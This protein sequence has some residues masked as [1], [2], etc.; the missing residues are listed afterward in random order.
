MKKTISIIGGGA[1]AIMCACELDTEKYE[2]TIYEK[3]KALGRKFLVAGKGGFN[4]THSEDIELFVDRY[5]PKYFLSDAIQNF[6]NQHLRNWL[7][8]NGILTFIGSSKRVYPEKGIKPIEVLKAF[9]SKMQTNKVHI[10]YSHNWLGWNESGSLNFDGENEVKSDIV[11]FALGG[12]SW[13]V[14]GSNGDWLGLF[15]DKGVAVAPFRASNCN[16]KVDWDREL[17]PKIEGLPLKNIAVSIDGVIQKGEAIITKQGIEGNAIYALSPMIRQSLDS[18]GEAVVGIDLKPI[19]DISKIKEKLNNSNYSKITEKL[20]NELKISKVQIELIK[21]IT[22][23]EEFNNIDFLAQIIKNLP[24]KITGLSPIDEAISTVGG[25]ALTEVNE[26][27]E[28]NKRL[29][30]FCIGEMLSWDA[31]T[32]GYLLQGCFSMGV[33]VAKALNAKN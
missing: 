14:T 33:A 21:S 19:F 29:N 6:N 30:H 13:K 18:K 3:N 31:P 15:Q 26:N 24:I 27:F 17:I 32:G 12:G 7:S 8:E 28:L 22:S 11:I 5:T 16:F 23:K 10:K 9:E 2:V 25:I 4:L 1:A 20:K